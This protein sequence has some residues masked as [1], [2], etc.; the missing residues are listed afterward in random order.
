MY[1][2]YQ[3]ND[4]ETKINENTLKCM[5]LNNYIGTLIYHTVKTNKKYTAEYNTNIE[6]FNENN[7]EIKDIHK[8]INEMIKDSKYEFTGGKRASI[9]RKKS[10]RKHKNKKHKH[11]KRRRH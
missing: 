3:D 5:Y 4:I 6:L 10:T 1:Y 9:R 7:Y 8:K 2:D 11:T